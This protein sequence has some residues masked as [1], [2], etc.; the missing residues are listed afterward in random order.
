[1]T[2]LA[3]SRN[4]LEF[5]NRRLYSCIAAHAWYK[6][7]SGRQPM[8]NVPQSES[9]FLT[10]LVEQE[11]RDVS[12]R[13]AQRRREL[14]PA[15]KLAENEKKRVQE[16]VRS[17]KQL[18]QRAVY[19]FVFLA[20]A[21]IA[22]IVAGVFASQ[23]GILASTNA[24]IAATVRAE[25]A[26]RATQQTIAEENFTRAEAQRLAAEANILLKSNADPELISLLSIHGRLIRL[27]P[28]RQRWITHY[29]YSSIVKIMYLRWAP[30]RTADM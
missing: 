15:Q 25:S 19:L 18:R 2:I 23:N 28:T 27:F 30:R 10:A 21:V 3:K 5:A 9:A 24:S 1:M 7:A 6:H 16:Q 11:E 4:S 20:L 14:E 17:I 26:A 13:E 22:A 8:K 12:E 29:M